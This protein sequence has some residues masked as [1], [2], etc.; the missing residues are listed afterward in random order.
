MPRARSVLAL[1][2]AVLVAGVGAETAAATKSVTVMSRNLYVGFD[3]TTILGATSPSDFVAR[4]T[5]GWLTVEA[6]AP[7][8][9][10]EAW[11][12]E[13]AATRP[14]VVG[15]QEAALYR[16]DMPADGR[17]SPAETVRY[18]F[19]ELLV[20]ALARRGLD[21]DIVAMF[22]GADIEAPTALGF[23]VRLTDR[24]AILVRGDR[25][26]GRL[27]VLDADTA[28]FATNLVVPTLAGPITIT[29]GW[30]S[31][32]AKLRG[33]TFRV[34]NTHLEAFATPIQVAQANELLAGPAATTRPVIALGDFNS[35]PGRM[36]PTYGLLLAAGFTD[37][38]A[39][40]GLTC[41]HAVNLRNPTPAF[42][43]R[44]DLVLERGRFNPLDAEVV[45]DEQA[46]RD[47]LG[48][49]P[50]DHGG[51]VATLRMR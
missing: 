18:D 2:A 50:S 9:R 21:Y 15:V 33:R 8:V 1:V 36:T 47:R 41:C 20:A 24:D 40:A 23:D 48:L 4:T 51:P 26:G 3:V 49:W 42:T 38:A 45:G 22:T 32:D 6:S 5:A 43:Q 31:V 16:L 44:I 14:D 27:K 17:L 35:G 29:R 28:S 7:G 34:L 37:A 25:G 10:A 39:G 19:L 13:I 11:A 46:V 30:E 12:D